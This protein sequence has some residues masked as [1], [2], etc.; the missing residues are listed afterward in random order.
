MPPPTENDVTVAVLALAKRL[1]WRPHRNH[2]GTFYTRDGRPVK[3]HK[4]GM[5]DW[6]LLHP[7]HGVCWVEVKRPGG[8]PSKEQREF[9]ASLTHAGYRVCLVESDSDL[10]LFFERWGLPTA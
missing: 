10:A 1:G 2:V 6:L 4:I 5:P 9:M 7:K 8:K 3:V